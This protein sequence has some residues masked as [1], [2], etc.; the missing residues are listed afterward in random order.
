MGTTDKITIAAALFGKTQR[1]LLSLFFARPQQPLYLRHIVRLTGIGQG[2]AQR[3]L[4]KW[5]KAGLL[6]RSQQGRLVYYQANR[7]VPVFAELRGLAVKTGGIVDVLK[8]ALMPLAGRL[9]VAFIYGSVARGEEKDGS[10]IDVLVV[11]KATFREVAKALTPAER[12][13]GR[14]INPTVYTEKEF[15]QKHEAGHHFLKTISIG[16]KL[17]LVGSEN[18]LKR[19]GA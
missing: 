12:A 18:E 6:L 4:A 17:F 7:E 3:E 14:E 10:D 5:V 1:A 8:E 11:G 13:L 16:P 2:A 19:L 9:R 15:H